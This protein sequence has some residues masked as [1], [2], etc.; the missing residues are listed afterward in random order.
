VIID[1]SDTSPIQREARAIELTSD[2]PRITLDA[3]EEF[4][5]PLR[6]IFSIASGEAQQPITT[7]SVGVAAEDCTHAAQRHADDLLGEILVGVN[8]LAQ[9]SSGSPRTGW[10]A[11][12]VTIRDNGDLVLEV[13]QRIRHTDFGEG[14]VAAITGEG[15]KTVAHVGS[16]S[17]GPKKLLVRLA[18]I[19][20][21]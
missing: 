18:P 2:R 17:E 20:L 8:A 4:V 21:I 16:D 14:T 1:F 5:E 3:I 19:D 12:V 15:P 11:P 6:R 9:R 13:G 7:L 10:T